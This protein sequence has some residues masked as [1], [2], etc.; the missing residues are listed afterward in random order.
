[1]Q[2]QELTE[3]LASR[4]PVVALHTHEEARGVDTARA[5]LA[6]FLDNKD[7]HVWD[8]ARGVDNT[9]TPT[10]PDEILAR[11]AAA[12]GL[13]P[14]G[15]GGEAKRRLQVQVW[16]LLDFHP[17]LKDAGVRR[18]VKNLRDGLRETR[19]SVVLL[20]PPE[21]LPDGLAEVVPVLRLPLPT[22]EEFAAM[23]SS[24]GMTGLDTGGVSVDAIVDALMGLTRHRAEAALRRSVAVHD[25]ADPVALLT[26]KAAD[27]RTGGVLELL[28]EDRR[29]LSDVGG[30]GAIVDFLRLRRAAFTNAGQAF[31]GT[32]PRGCTIAG[33]PGTGKSLIAKAIAGEW[34]LPLARLDMGR[35]YGS[36]VG[37]SEGRMR[38]AL[39][40]VDRISPSVLWVDEAEK[41]LGGTGDGDS[42]VGKRVLGTLLTWL[43]ERKSPSFV[44]FTVN[45]VLNLPPEL[46]RKGRVD[47]LFWVDLPDRTERQVIFTIHL[48]NRRKA[49]NG[50]APASA[51]D[52]PALADA[53]AGF[54][55]SEIEQ[56]VV[57]GLYAAFDTG[58]AVLTQAHM[59][60]EA[61]AAIPLSKTAADHIDA[62]RT[63]ARSHAR[64]AS[65]P[66]AGQPKDASLII[67]ATNSPAGHAS[68]TMDVLSL[69]ARKA[70]RS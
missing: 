55:G 6:A 38:D 36:L 9:G 25:K 62:M 30:Y 43:Q 69:G 20:G 57:S 27:L 10:R 58:A 66:A 48:E 39:D 41:A 42:G 51:Y 33:P 17:Y 28:T 56:V 60:S 35:V 49:G 59:L 32:Y 37:Q 34:G 19:T 5:A 70:A 52:L 24:E 67:D 61:T 2:Q 16:V 4:E 13:V 14:D 68:R 44:V 3:V 18:R 54:S 8:V 50:V 47:E 64:N 26:Y 46:L 1:M 15:A 65:Y 63:W 22:R 7:F 40:R 12:A 23:L 29:T 31:I 21:D 45:S 11:V 53:T